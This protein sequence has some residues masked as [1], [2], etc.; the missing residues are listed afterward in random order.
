MCVCVRAHHIYYK[1]VISLVGKC[2]KTFSPADCFIYFVPN[3]MWSVKYNEFQLDCSYYLLQSP[4]GKYIA[5]GALDGI[6]NVF[7]ISTG[8]LIH[9]LEGK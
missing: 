7:D 8:K 1:L 3:Q 2:T 6:V 5:S 4:D 9:T